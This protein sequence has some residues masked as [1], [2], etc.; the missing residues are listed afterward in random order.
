MFDPSPSIPSNSSPSTS[1]ST[2]TLDLRDGDVDMDAKRRPLST[3]DSLGGG[4]VFSTWAQ[5]PFETP[6]ESGEGRGS[7]LISCLTSRRTSVFKGGGSVEWMCLCR[8]PPGSQRSW[9]S[10][11]RFKACLVM[12]CI[13]WQ[14]FW[15]PCDL[16]ISGGNLAVRLPHFWSRYTDALFLMVIPQS[17]LDSD[18]ESSLLSARPRLSTFGFWLKKSRAAWGGWGRHQLPT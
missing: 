13:T 7:F 9:R 8:R 5:S 10:I 3:G 4:P 2:S 17:C 11:R 18:L 15:P 6:S 1:T 14:K 12:D 16:P